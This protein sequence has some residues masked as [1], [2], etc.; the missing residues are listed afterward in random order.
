MLKMQL[1]LSGS[2]FFLPLQVPLHRCFACIHSSTV[3]QLQF[4]CWHLDTEPMTRLSH[5]GLQLGW[6]RTAHSWRFRLVTIGTAGA[7]LVT[8]EG[9][10]W[11]TGVVRGDVNPTCWREIMISWELFIQKSGGE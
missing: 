4:L 5:S 8:G 7:H 3:A 11:H 1:L 6:V 2:S 10:D 9:R